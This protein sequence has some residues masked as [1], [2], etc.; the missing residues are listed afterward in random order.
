MANREAWRQILDERSSEC[1]SDFGSVFAVIVTHRAAC[2][3]GDWETVQEIEDA[4]AGV[5]LEV[6]GNGGGRDSRTLRASLLH[7]QGVR[8][9]TQG[10]FSAAVDRFRGADDRLSFIQVADGMLKL[11]NHLFLV[12]TMLAWG[13]DAEAHKALAWVRST[14]PTMAAEFETSGFRLLGLGRG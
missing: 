12:E 5:L 3:T 11:Q 1:V 8:L 7:M 10:D 2:R 6:E 14:N 9:A 4:A 13:K